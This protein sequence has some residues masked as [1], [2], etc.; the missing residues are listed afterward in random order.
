MQIANGTVYFQTKDDAY[1]FN[2]SRISKITC[3]EWINL[4][5]YNNQAYVQ[6][7]DKEKECQIFNIKHGKIK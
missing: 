4:F 7:Y 5:I 3:I 2:F 6:E 1:E